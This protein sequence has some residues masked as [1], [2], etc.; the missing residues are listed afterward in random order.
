MARQKLRDIENLEI[1]DLKWIKELIWNFGAKKEKETNWKCLTDCKDKRK[2][3]VV[4]HKKEYSFSC[5]RTC[6][7]ECYDLTALQQK[8]KRKRKGLT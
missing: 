5:S 4:K 3:N 1:S 2:T 7:F 8:E 6:P